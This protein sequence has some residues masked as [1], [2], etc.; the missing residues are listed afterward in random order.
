MTN[1]NTNMFLHKIPILPTENIFDDS[2]VTHS[3]VPPP[4]LF[5][6]GYHSFLDRTQSAMNITQQLKSQDEFYYIVNPFEYIIKNYPDDVKSS[7]FIPQTSEPVIISRDFY[8]IWEILS[9]FNMVDKQKINIV[10]LMK[11]SCN[12]IQP[13][14]RYREKFH[15]LNQDKIYSVQ[16]DSEYNDLNKIVSTYYNEKYPKLI[17]TISQEK[18][19]TQIEKDKTYAQL[20]IGGNSPPKKILVN[21]MK[22]Q[23]SYYIIFNEILT[24]IKTLDKNGNFILKMFDTF[25]TTSIKMIYL[26][27]HFFEEVLIY[28]PFFSRN[29]NSD[30]YII[31]RGFKY[32]QG[33]P[34]L[35]KKIKF[36]EMTF[37]SIKTDKYVIDIFPKF[38]ITDQYMNVIKYTNTLL[39]N[40]RQILI[41]QLVVYIKSNNYFGDDY[42]MYRMKQIAA[43]KWWLETYFIEERKDFSKNIKD[44]IHYNESELNLFIKKFI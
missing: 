7:P 25:T 27:T 26:L 29:T 13:F 6:L 10:G 30:K 40:T 36:L 33:K 43:N 21:N 24:G 22:E 9:T 17:N 41:N 38:N 35:V 1:T 18:L 44:L 32:E 34:E 19:V 2:T 42:H 31:C 39:I 28:K 11:D 23:E 12:F 16:S 8:I 5:S 20:V 3:G 4:P 14:I 15:K 37:K